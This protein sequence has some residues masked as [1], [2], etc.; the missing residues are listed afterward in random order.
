M[1][2]INLNNK[3]VKLYASIKEMPIRLYNLSQKYLLQDMGI[4]SDM[5]A[6]DDHFSTLDSYL[7]AGKIE[8]ALQERENQRFAFFTMIQG[9]SYKSLSFACHVH[10]IAGELITDHSEEA[11]NKI[12]DSFDFSMSECENILDD[13][14]KNFELN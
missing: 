6:I 4:G 2:T 8:E 9:V 14:K 13:L 11:L 12:M 7:S 10:S 3:E 5:N 1:L